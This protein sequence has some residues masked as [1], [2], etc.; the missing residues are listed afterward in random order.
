MHR[1]LW[2]SDMGERSSFDVLVD[3]DQV[4]LPLPERHYSGC[5]ATYYV[6][7]YLPVCA[8]R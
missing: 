8:P 6:C 2:T 4:S 1:T 7:R 5:H 3:S